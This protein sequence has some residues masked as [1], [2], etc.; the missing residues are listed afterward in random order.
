MGNSSAFFEAVRNRRTIYGLEAK[1]PIPDERI[2]EIVN[3]TIKH[4]P[5][6]F[7]SQSARA[8]VLL[9]AEHQ[10]LWDLAIEALKAVVPPENFSQT[11]AKLNGFKAAYGTVLWFED[12]DPVRA[13]EEAFPTY[14]DKFPV[15]SAHASGMN[16]YVAWTALEAEG[17]GANLQHYSPLIDE[18]VAAEWKIPQNWQLQSQLVFG[19]PLAPAGEKS[20]K[21]LQERVKVYGAEA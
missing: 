6:S 11:E 12:Q 10:K 17:F 20:F 13:L 15:F 2:I 19:T 1:S 16:Q 9:K 4:V 21:P 3:D 7:N 18:K 8:I 5:S 14:A